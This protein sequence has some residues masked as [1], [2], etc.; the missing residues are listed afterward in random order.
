VSGH[1]A[2]SLAGAEGTVVGDEGLFDESSP[3]QAA[4]TLN[5]RIAQSRARNADT[6]RRGGADLVGGCLVIVTSL[7]PKV[8]TPTE[9]AHVDGRPSS[10]DA[11]DVQNRQGNGM[12]R[13]LFVVMVFVPFV[14][15]AQGD[16]R[17][18]T[19]PA[20]AVK[21]LAASL[22]AARSHKTHAWRDTPP[23]NSDGTVNAY[24]EIARGDRR[25]WEFDMG[26]NR[27]KID[28]M[29]PV[30]IG[31][32]PVNYGFV[33]QTVSYDGDP[34]DALVLGPALPDGRFVR[35]IAVGVMYMEDEKGLDSKVVLSRVDAAGRPMHQL[36]P[37]IQN[38]IGGYFARYKSLG[39]DTWSKVPGWGTAEQ[40]LAFVKITHA[41]FQQCATRT[42]PCSIDSAR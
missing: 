9:R 1:D 20:K 42:G 21:I 2:S 29:I 3:P 18:S 8:S 10:C 31:G 5:A 26:T 28:R 24:I 17:P 23:I 11:G 40:G 15:G 12:T 36:T 35:G 19:L 27:R 16:M 41:F 22:D 25:K 34:F 37:A 33:P 7:L 4:T 30:E 39:R 32:Y 38:E 14:V 13:L 6:A